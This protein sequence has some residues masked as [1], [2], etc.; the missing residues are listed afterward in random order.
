MHLYIDFV[1]IELQN[2]GR[3]NDSTRHTWWKFSQSRQFRYRGREEKNF[4]EK[5]FFFHDIVSCVYLQGGKQNDF[6]FAVRL[7]MKQ[8]IWKAH[9]PFIFISVRKL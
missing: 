2:M 4:I 7:K 6:L 9:V 1:N 8:K 3:Y 5:S